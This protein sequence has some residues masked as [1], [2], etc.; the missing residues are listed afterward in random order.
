MGSLDDL[1]LGTF[2]IWAFDFENQPAA[3][4]RESR[5]ELEEQGWQAFWIPELLGREA[6]THVFADRARTIYNTRRTNSDGRL[7]TRSNGGGDGT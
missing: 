1:D 5:E 6:F 4:M 3:Q 2:G 7:V